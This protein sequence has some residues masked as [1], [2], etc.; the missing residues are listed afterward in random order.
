MDRNIM[1]KLKSLGMENGIDL[2]K[3][4]PEKILADEA[5]IDVTTI[6]QPADDMMMP[7]DGSTINLVSYVQSIS[8]GIIAAEESDVMQMIAE[9]IRIK[10]M[11]SSEIES[12]EKEDITGSM[13]ELPMY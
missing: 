7:E 1:E 9:I 4:M 3:I 2:S 8:D 5:N 12:P 6:T 10:S 11:N 13:P